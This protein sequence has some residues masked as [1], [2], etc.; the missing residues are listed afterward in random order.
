ML[1]RCCDRYRAMG[2]NEATK[3]VHR[4]PVAWDS[5]EMKLK[6]PQLGSERLTV[7]MQRICLDE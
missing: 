6:P 2:L 5:L 1:H 3:A 7:P 4:R